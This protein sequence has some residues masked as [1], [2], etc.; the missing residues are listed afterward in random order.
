MREVVY[1]EICSNFGPV[2]GN[3]FLE[4][5]HKASD[6]FDKRL[7]YTRSVAVSSILGYIVGLGDRHGANI[8]LDLD[9]AEV[10]H[11][12]LGIAFEQGKTLR[13]PELVPFRLT[14][15]VVDGMGISGVEGV[16]RRCCEVSLRLLRENKGLLM[17]AME[18]FLY[19]PLF[20]WL[21]S[22]IEA[23]QLQENLGEETPINR[24][25]W[26]ALEVQDRSD[27][28]IH[29][30]SEAAKALLRI[31][32]KLQVMRVEQKRILNSTFSLTSSISAFLPGL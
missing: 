6:W 8:L 25:G 5:F 24:F 2:L 21:L 18:V 32:D 13:T 22:P 20:K 30:N 1:E 11:I 10:V 9:T 17:T 15:D 29:L 27:D 4:R 14:R 16:F 23:L 19:D 7:S 3:F 26:K 28:I 31:K 12:D